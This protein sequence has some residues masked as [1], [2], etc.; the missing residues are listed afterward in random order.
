MGPYDVVGALNDGGTICEGYAVVYREIAERMGAYCERVVSK[1]MNHAWNYIVVDGAGYCTDVTW[2]DSTKE[3]FNML[4][5]QEMA[6]THCFE[7]PQHGC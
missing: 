6:K 3:S 4:T 2:Q 7:T 1:E 5:I